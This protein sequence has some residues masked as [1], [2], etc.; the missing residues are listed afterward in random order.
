VLKRVS[1]LI[2]V[3]VTA[4]VGL[5]AT[6]AGAS[7]SSCSGSVSYRGATAKRITA[8]RTSCSTAK[9]IAYRINKA[10]VMSSGCTQSMDYPPD[11]CQV[12]LNTRSA[13]WKCTRSKANY[14]VVT[15]RSGRARVGMTRS[16]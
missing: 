12:R 9:D 1:G 7:A 10:A 11:G 13:W 16:G 6:P 5:A 4:S 14:R 8:T 2:V 15:C 3:A